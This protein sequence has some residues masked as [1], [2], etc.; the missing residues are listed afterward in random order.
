MFNFCAPCNLNDL[1]S[2]TFPDGKRFYTLP[3]G[4][5]VPSVTT[6]LGARPK[7]ALMKWRKEIGEVQ[8]NA[9]T[10]KSTSRGTN[11]HKICEDY[12]NNK[13][14]YLKGVM[15]D[16]QEMFKSIKPLI[17]KH[18]TDIWYQETALWSKKLNM[19][20]RVDLIAH[21]DGVLSIIDFKTSN[22]IKK[23][24]YVLDYFLQETTYA[25]ML[26]EMINIPVNQI[27]TL[28]AVVD[29][30]PQV[31]IEKTEDHINALVEAI[32]YYN[33]NKK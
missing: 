21:W 33:K 10:K 1:Q 27:V 16:A 30:K 15:P 24:E 32:N 20:G 7:E 6:V 19:A 5:R 31:F 8:A 14:E 12:I 23:R 11:M 4:T 9:I 2:E 3:D 17:D 18:V 13:P 22:K 26:E 28:I 29:E 25:L